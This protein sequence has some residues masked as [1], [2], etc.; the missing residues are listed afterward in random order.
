MSAELFNVSLRTFREDYMKGKNGNFV[1][2]RNV[3]ILTNIVI[4][5]LEIK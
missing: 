3:F 1:S 4:S 2:S 5:N